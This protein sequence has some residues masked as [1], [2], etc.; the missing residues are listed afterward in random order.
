MET[1]IHQILLTFP[2][3]PAEWKWAVEGCFLLQTFLKLCEEVC[4]NNVLVQDSLR[5]KVDQVGAED[6]VEPD[7]VHGQDG[8]RDVSLHPEFIFRK[9]L[10]QTKYA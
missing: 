2:V 7:L 10:L 6:A 1:T 4:V 9:N 5:L 3:E 8:G